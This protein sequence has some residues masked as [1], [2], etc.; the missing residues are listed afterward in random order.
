MSISKKT[1]LEWNNDAGP[2]T[3]FSGGM[4]P[5]VSVCTTQSKIYM[6]TLIF[7][8]SYNSFSN[9]AITLHLSTNNHHTG[10]QLYAFLPPIIY[11]SVYHHIHA[12]N[13]NGFSGFKI[14]R[15][16]WGRR[17]LRHPCSPRK[18]CSTVQRQWRNVSILSV[19]WTPAI[20]IVT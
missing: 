4:Q 16:L 7:A 11:Y 14:R 8:Y 20:V 3:C 18:L 1:R 6:Q 2:S 15:L 5:S 13:Q 19:R 12:I 10:Y 17:F 9:S